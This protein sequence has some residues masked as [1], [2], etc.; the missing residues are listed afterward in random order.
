MSHK[1]EL[2]LKH[3]EEM[4]EVE[5]LEY[6]KKLVSSAISSRKSLDKSLKRELAVD[7]FNSSRASRTT[8]F[9]NSF[10]S[11]SVYYQLIDDIKMSMTIL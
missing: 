4:S 1:R 5:K 3:T 9:A 10:K 7:P 2:L 6:V 11:N 8:A